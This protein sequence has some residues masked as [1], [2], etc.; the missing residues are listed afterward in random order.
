MRMI[1]SPTRSELRSRDLLWVESRGLRRDSSGMIQ[2]AF[3][4]E[5]RNNLKIAV[6]ATTQ[7]STEVILLAAK[8]EVHDFLRSHGERAT[9]S[10]IA[11]ATGYHTQ[12]ARKRA[13]ELLSEG[14][15][16]G[17]KSK[18]IPA[19]IIDDDYVVLT[20]DRGHL[21][22][23]VRDYGTSSLHSRA[24]S[25]STEQ[26]QRLIRRRLAD[27]VVGGPKVWEFWV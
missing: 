3:R 19:V 16:Q 4:N 13:K 24:K 23:I 10:E 12:T 9:T 21:L 18:R 15:I 1:E 22:D 27:D 20:D 11:D 8:E 26:I 14:R 7:P 17:S 6:S 25:M 2:T 5:A